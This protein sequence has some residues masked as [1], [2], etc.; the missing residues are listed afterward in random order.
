[1]KYDF[2]LS[3]L[4]THDKEYAEEIIDNTIRKFGR[5]K[6]I[7]NRDE[8]KF[9]IITDDLNNQRCNL[10]DILRYMMKYYEDIECCT[11]YDFDMLKFDIKVLKIFPRYNHI[12]ETIPIY[13]GYVKA[14]MAEVDREMIRMFRDC[15]K[16]NLLTKEYIDEMRETLGPQRILCLKP[17]EFLKQQEPDEFGGIAICD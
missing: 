12:Q 4:K 8:L 16:H 11:T 10:E 13:T 2:D 1:M 17:I 9:T 14:E 6:N 15:V 7:V 3:Q 5:C